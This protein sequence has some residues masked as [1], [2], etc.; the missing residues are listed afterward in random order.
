[1][2][3]NGN[4]VL[5]YNVLLIMTNQYKDYSIHY[6][7]KP[8][9]QSLMTH[10]VVGLAGFLQQVYNLS[11]VHEKHRL[12]TTAT[13]LPTVPLVC[14]MGAHTIVFHCSARS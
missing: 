10:P 6:S 12:E 3:N 5:K 14:S 11:Q 13:E 7:E 1:M 4:Q 8:K 9:T 2:C